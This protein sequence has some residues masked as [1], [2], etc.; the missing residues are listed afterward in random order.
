[1]AHYGAGPDNGVQV[2]T[3]RAG[4]G[5]GDGDVTRIRK[6]LGARVMHLTFVS[7]RNIFVAACTDLTLRS[8][9]YDFQ[10]NNKLQLFYSIH[11][12]VY[13]EDLDVLV[14]GSKG[15]LQHWRLSKSLQVSDFIIF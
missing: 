3:A 13:N 8:Y 10:L 4:A 6:S 1:M 15:R 11:S 7:S 2:W 14:T 12:M 5:V 9:D